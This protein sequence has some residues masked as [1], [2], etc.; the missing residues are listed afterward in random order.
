MGADQNFDWAAATASA[1]EWW[2]DA[3]VDVLVE[4]APRDWLS[5]PVP[6]IPPAPAAVAPAAMPATLAVFLDWRM[7]SDMPEASWTGASIAAS[8]P[9]TAELMILA[10]CPDR[11][12]AGVLLSGGAAGRLF[13][14]MLAA[15]GVAREDVHMAATCWRRPTAG[16]MPRDAEARLGEIARHHVALVEPKRLLLLGDGAARAVL[17][18]HLAEAR[19]RLHFV[20]HD[21]RRVRAVASHH[22]RFLIEK[23]ACKAESW[24]DLRMLV[25]ESETGE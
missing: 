8:G 17:G 13:T 16:R 23:P 10:D 4:D 2:R 7:G 1:L 18:I 19:G 12:D 21:G 11:D 6:A 14:R 3:G 15:I 5:A 20:N 24:S 22:P 9:D 25:R